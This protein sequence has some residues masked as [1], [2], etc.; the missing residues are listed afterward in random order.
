MALV[1]RLSV[2]YLFG[3]TAYPIS[4][5]ENAFQPEV[6]TICAHIPK[7]GICEWV[8]TQPVST[9]FYLQINGTPPIKHILVK[10]DDL[11]KMF[12]RGEFIQN[13]HF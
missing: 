4:Q 6:Q 9:I 2:R 13:T 5:L 1:E 10:Q 11:L 12:Q 8:R 3:D 7:R